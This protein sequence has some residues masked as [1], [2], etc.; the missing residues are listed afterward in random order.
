[1]QD[2]E[3]STAWRNQGAMERGG[4]AHMQAFR[5]FDR[6]GGLKAWEEFFTVCAD[7]TFL[8]G[9]AKPQPG[10]PPFFA[11]IDFLFSPKGFA[12]CIEN[13]YHREVA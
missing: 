2:T 1:M 13:K 4:K 9:Q 8:T 10:K 6:A 11:D 5:V 7:S 12:G 3:P